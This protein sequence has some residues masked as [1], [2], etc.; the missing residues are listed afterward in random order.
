MHNFTHVHSSGRYDATKP[1]FIKALNTYVGA[2][3]LITVTEVHLERR[4]QIMRE[5]AKAHNY[6]VVTGD[7]SARDDC[8]IMYDKE[9]WEYITGFTRKTIPAGAYRQ[10]DGTPVQ[11]AY[12]VFAVLRHKV[13][14]KKILVTVA[15]LPPT[16]EVK[17]RFSPGR[18]VSRAAAWRTGQKNWKNAWN[19]IARNHEVDGVMIVAD[20]NLNIKSYPIR[21]FLQSL[22]RGMTLVWGN[23][24]YPS[25]GTHGRRIIDFT[26]VRGAVKRIGR[27]VLMYDDASSD[28][29]PYKE[30]LGI[31][32]A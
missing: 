17:G 11:A 27:P 23:G 18:S 7:G 19:L 21:M 10:V 15:H 8:G 9:V 22:Q 13:S 25:G 32:T 26:Y 31:D 16:V 2:A 24:P 4:E 12:A 20:W 5:V 30:L 1:S 3:S 29:R 6:G 14:K 28:H